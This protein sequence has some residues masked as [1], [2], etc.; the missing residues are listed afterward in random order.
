MVRD[1]LLMPGDVA[2]DHLYFWADPPVEALESQAALLEVMAPLLSSLSSLGPVRLRPCCS[3]RPRATPPAL[4][5]V[6][7]RP[8]L[9]RPP[10]ACRASFLA[11]LP[12]TCAL[13]APTCA[14]APRLAPSGCMLASIRRVQA[15]GVLGPGSWVGAEQRAR[16]SALASWSRARGACTMQQPAAGKCMTGGRP[17]PPLVVSSSRPRTRASRP[18]SIASRCCAAASACAGASRERL[19][20]R[21]LAAQSFVCARMRRPKCCGICC[22]RVST[23]H[24]QY[25]HCP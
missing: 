23:L 21:R 12:P 2:K 3:R 15:R 7:P 13:P 4:A 18:P 20:R 17:R 24:H 10:S 11:R 6:T 8:R 5:G 9:P 25:G 14:A 22:C 16:R 19:P 1:R